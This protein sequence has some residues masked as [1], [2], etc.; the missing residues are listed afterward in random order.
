VLRLGRLLGTVWNRVL[1]LRAGCVKANLEAAFPDRGAAWR[2]RVKRD[3]FRHFATVALE[4]AWLPRVDDRWVAERVRFLNR[5]LPFEMLARGRGVVAVGGH[6]GNWEL[7]GA[8]SARIGIPLT[9]IVKRVHDPLLDR[10]VN[11]A[12]EYHGAETIY[13]RDSG[14]VLLKHF[15]RGR[16]VAF[17][18]DQDAGRQGIFVPFFGRPAST[19][20]GA[21][22]IALRLKLPLLFV[23]SR[24]LPGGRYEMEYVEVPVEEHWSAC[25]EDIRVLTARFTAMLEER[26]RECPEQWFWMHRRWKTGPA[27]T[28]PDEG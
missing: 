8:A 14:R 28:A 21:A 22:A 4:L 18:S 17:I 2:R 1:P 6:F 12:R 16:L 23:S 11:E 20:R 19:P 13:T 26:I 15:R 7:Q 5:E 3:C 24:R 25:E 27:G 9:I 10:L